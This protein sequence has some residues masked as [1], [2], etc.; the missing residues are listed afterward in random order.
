MLLEV[1]LFSSAVSFG[2]IIQGMLEWG[3]FSEGFRVGILNN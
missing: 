1:N 3:V 2:Q